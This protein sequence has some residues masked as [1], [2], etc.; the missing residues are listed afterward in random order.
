MIMTN[1]E[2]AQKAVDC[3]EER[4]SWTYCHGA[5]GKPDY[6]VGSSKVR[7]L[8][9]YFLAIGKNTTEIEYAA[10]EAEHKGQFCCDCSNFINYLMGFTC[11]AWSTESFKSME[12]LDGPM[13]GAICYKAGHVG[14]AINADEFVHMPYYERSFERVRFDSMPGYWESYHKLP[15]QF[16]TYDKRKDAV[17]VAIKAQ[18]KAAQYKIGYKLTAADIVV[19]VYM[20]D[21]SS[22]TTPTLQGWRAY[23]LEI[24]APT[25]TITVEYKGVKTELKVGGADYATDIYASLKHEPYPIG[26]ELTAADFDIKVK[27]AS[28]PVIGTPAL[29]HW[30]A[31][32]LLISKKNEKIKVWWNDKTTTITVKTV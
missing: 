16:V 11:S 25:N 26:T 2:F 23:P 18:T 17:P 14:I 6:F 19:T 7:N 20:S 4:D 9:E 31:S 29:Q 21:G 28:G 3:W 10:W 27:M 32:P 15:A 22:K 5:I 24:K 13:A 1:T 12:R 8:Y 30:G